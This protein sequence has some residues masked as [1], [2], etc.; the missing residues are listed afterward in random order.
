MIET[1]SFAAKTIKS[2]EAK[3]QLDAKSR[4]KRVPNTAVLIKIRTLRLRKTPEQKL[5]DLLVVKQPPRKRLMPR[6]RKMR[7]KVKFF[8]IFGNFVPFFADMYMKLDTQI[9]SFFRRN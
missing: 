3:V 9:I 6:K 4:P 8:A 2:L 7:K 1:F 5:L